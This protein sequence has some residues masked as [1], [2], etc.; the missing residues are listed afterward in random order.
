MF[1]FLVIFVKAVISVNDRN[2]M[3]LVHLTSNN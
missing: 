3:F 2:F 1:G